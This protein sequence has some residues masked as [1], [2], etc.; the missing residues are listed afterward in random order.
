MRLKAA[1]LIEDFMR[2]NL[3]NYGFEDRYPKS[4]DKSLQAIRSMA[5]FAYSD[6]R[7]HRLEGKH[8]L[9]EKEKEVFQRCILFLNTELEYSGPDDF[10]DAT[11]GLKRL[12][13]WITRSTESVEAEWMQWWPFDSLEQFNR[14]KANQ[15]I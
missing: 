11:A 7:E 15:P 2:G 10:F 9:T 5:W 12:W 14:Y 4:A 3:T 1:H 8:A 13:H 6:L